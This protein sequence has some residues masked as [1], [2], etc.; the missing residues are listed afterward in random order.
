MQHIQPGE[1]AGVVLAAG[2][3]IRFGSDK[4]L[5]YWQ[6]KPILYW[7]LQVLQQCAVLAVNQQPQQQHLEVN[8][9]TRL[10]AWHRLE[11][12]EFIN[13]GP[14][15]GIYNALRWTQ[16][17][18]YQWL[19]SVSIDCLPLPADFL[20]RLLQQLQPGKK[21]CV[22]YFAQRRFFTHAIWSTELLPAMRNFLQNEAAIWQF[23]QNHPISVCQFS[24]TLHNINTQAQ[25]QQ[26][27][28]SPLL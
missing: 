13:Q 4:A 14:L 22:A 24:Q 28:K 16:Q 9:P 10:P 25:W 19:C 5:L 1:V 12:S 6:N 21:G 3:S 26:L 7:Q 8:L 15:S 11:D 20:P 2:K 17:Q 23:V 27:L 18:G